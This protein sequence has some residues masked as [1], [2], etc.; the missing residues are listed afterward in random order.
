MTEQPTPGTGTAQADGLHR[1]HIG[2]FEGPLDLLLHLVRINEIDITDIPV[3]EVAR[4]YAEYLDLMRELNLEIAGE[5]LV[6]AATLIQIKSQML[7]PR[8]P[9]AD[10]DEDDPRDELTRQLLDYQKYKQAA[11]NLQA[12]DSVRGLIW[13]RDGRVPEEFRGEEL[14][15]VE[16][17]DLL[18][19]FNRLL[20]R[21]DDEARL[22]L[23]AD[24]V[25]VAEKIHWISELLEQRES[26]EFSEMMPR[27][28]TRLDR[29]GVFLALLEMLRLRMLVAF[30]RQP[31]GEIRIARWR[32][33]PTSVGVGAPA[34]DDAGQGDPHGG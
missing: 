2:T 4:Q 19:T 15:T 34:M 1:F 26:V 27:M 9:D 28:S 30:Q 7:L 6:M 17:F 12:I 11:E 31:L 3:A 32:E 8:D 29:I 24:N 20:G 10:E 22:R 5:Y 25:S 18:S 21:L 33:D 14:L 16:L 13:T 23:K